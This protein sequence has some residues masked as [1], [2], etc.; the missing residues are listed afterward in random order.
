MGKR[1]A[2]NFKTLTKIDPSILRSKPTAVSL[3]AAHDGTRVT[4]I[5]NPVRAPPVSPIDPLAF[6]LGRGDLNEDLE[7]EEDASKA[8][9]VARDNPLLLR[10][11]ERGLFLEEFIRLEGRGTTAND[12]C[13]LCREEGI[14]RCTDCPAVQLLC[15]GCLRRIHS[16]NPFHVVEK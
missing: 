6:G 10:R 8:Y 1:K 15:G 7:E 5:L 14:Y 16:L 9:Y 2:R 12:R 4:T 11:A 3:H 13:K